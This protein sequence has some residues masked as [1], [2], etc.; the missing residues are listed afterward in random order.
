VYIFDVLTSKEMSC[1]VLAQQQTE[2]TVL[3]CWFSISQNKHQ[4]VTSHCK[5]Q[6]KFSESNALWMKCFNVLLTFWGKQK[7]LSLIPWP[8]TAMLYFWRVK[9]SL[10]LI[11]KSAIPRR[12]AVK[13]NFSSRCSEWSTLQLCHFPLRETA[14]GTF[15]RSLGLE[16]DWMLQKREVS[17]N[18][19]VNWTDFLAI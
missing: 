9:L 7:K 6:L 18:L 10:C 13:W 1:F 4:L 12:H 3:M 19:T 8:S 11:K 5:L 17:F 15:Y 16:P 2:G 14:P